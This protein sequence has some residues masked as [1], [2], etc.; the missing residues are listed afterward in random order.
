MGLF[1]TLFNRN[2]RQWMIQWGEESSAYMK[3]VIDGF[4]IKDNIDFELYMENNR[5]NNKLMS[6]WRPHSGYEH[7]SDLESIIPIRP[8]PTFK[9]YFSEED[10]RAPGNPDWFYIGYPDVVK[11]IQKNINHFSHWEKRFEQYEFGES[12]PLAFFRE[13]I[14]EYKKNHQLECKF[15]TQ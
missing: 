8:S 13:V 1:S 2:K 7:D 4:F 10:F 11:W 9:K 15:K 12:I 14:D 3:R 5:A 6:L